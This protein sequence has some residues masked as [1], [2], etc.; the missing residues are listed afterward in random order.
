VQPC[1]SSAADRRDIVIRCERVEEDDK[2]CWSSSNMGPQEHHENECQFGSGAQ[3]GRRDSGVWIVCW[4]R[5]CQ[6]SI[7]KD[8]KIEFFVNDKTQPDSHVRDGRQIRPRGTS[9]AGSA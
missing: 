5:Q 2:G 3:H 6:N 4:P 9:V 7:P 1:G 8:F